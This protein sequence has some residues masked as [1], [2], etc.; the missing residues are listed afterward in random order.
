MYLETLLRQS[1]PWFVI[2]AVFMLCQLFINFKHGMVFSPFY[3]Y[4][5]YSEVMKPAASYQVFSITA[6]GT[7]L[8]TQDF[9]PQQWD[10]IMQ[11]VLFYAKHAEANR[12]MF[13]EVHRLTGITDSSH[14]INHTND[15]GFMSWYKKYLGDILHRQ[16]HTVAI[17][18]KTYRP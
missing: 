3:H 1:K 15:T 5:M 9:T 6:D 8:K 13:A 18:P 11:P 2:A 7:E 16:V 10:K 14:Y 4:G 12:Q 17:Q